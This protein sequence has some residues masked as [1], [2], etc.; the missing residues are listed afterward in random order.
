MGAAER[1]NILRTC[2]VTKNYER[3][4]NDGDKVFAMPT[5]EIADC[6]ERLRHLT[7]CLEIV[8]DAP[9]QPALGAAIFLT[10]ELRQA[11]QDLDDNMP[12]AGMLKPEAIERLTFWPQDV[13]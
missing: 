9:G 11:I 10:A 2:I 5:R 1:L 13:V 6:F 3:I 8:L 4:C 7:E 12:T